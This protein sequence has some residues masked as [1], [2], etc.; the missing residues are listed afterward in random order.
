MTDAG[1]VLLEPTETGIGLLVSTGAGGLLLEPHAAT[2]VI[3]V[4]TT[5]IMKY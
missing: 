4:T 2:A 1:N 5:L 3:A